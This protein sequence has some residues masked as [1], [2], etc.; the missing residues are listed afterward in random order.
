MGDQHDRII[1]QLRKDVDQLAADYRTMKRMY[2][3]EKNSNKVYVQN[4]QKLEKKIRDLIDEKQS[5]MNKCHD[6]E[7]ELASIKESIL[8]PISVRKKWNELKSPN[9]RWARKLKYKSV[10][11]KSI[12]CIIECKRARVTLTLGGNDLNLTWSEQEMTEHKERLGFGQDH[13][14]LVTNQSV[15]TSSLA[16]DPMSSASDA[17]DDIAVNVNDNGMKSQTR[18]LITVMDQ[19]RISHKAYHELKKATEGNVIPAISQIKKEK[20]KMSSEIPFTTHREV[21]FNF[22]LVE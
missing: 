7:S 14:V 2:S 21:N 19:H 8:K 15:N 16:N 22:T 5:L 9:S 6:L 13:Q 4:A 20:S 1:Y 12:Q 18:K 10:I 17:A 3:E 11:D